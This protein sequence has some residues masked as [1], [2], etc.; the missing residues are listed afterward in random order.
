MSVYVHNI[1]I[2]KVLRVKYFNPKEI[3]IF[4]EPPSHTSDYDSVKMVYILDSYASLFY[5]FAESIKPIRYIPFGFSTSFPHQKTFLILF[6]SSQVLLGNL[7]QLDL[8]NAH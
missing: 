1:R 3:D 7:K 8:V 6:A 2:W 5:R 4:L